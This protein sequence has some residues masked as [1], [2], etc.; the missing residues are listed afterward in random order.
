MKSHPLEEEALQPQLDR[1]TIGG[2]IALD[3]VGRFESLQCDFDRIC[4]L[5]RIEPRP[6]QHVFKT[7]HAHY[8]EYYD[9][10]TRKIVEELYGADIAAFGYRFD[11]PPRSPQ[12]GNARRPWAA[13]WPQR[14]ANV[15]TFDFAPMRSAGADVQ[16]RDPSRF[17]SVAAGESSGIRVERLG[18]NPIIVPAM[19]P[20]TDGNN[21]NGP[22]LIRVPAW[23]KNPLGRYYL[24]FAHHEGKYIRLAYAD[25]LAGAWTVTKQ[26]RSRLRTRLAMP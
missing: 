20:G 8:A 1:V 24:Y 3:F 2:A 7:N 15:G 26:A 16:R 11:D 22:S 9:D 14:V 17:Q 18:G 10:E 23:I 12:N 4:S 6:L 5:L 13:A 19:L 21:I 25:E